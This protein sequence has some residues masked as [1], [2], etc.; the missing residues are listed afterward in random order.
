MKCTKCNA[1]NPN[2]VIFC[3]NCGALVQEAE[4][5]LSRTSSETIVEGEDRA[6]YTQSDE[7]QQPYGQPNGNQPGADANA[8]GNAYS[9]NNAPKKDNDN[10]DNGDGHKADRIAMV[11]FIVI[12]CILLLAAN[13][14]SLVQTAVNGDNIGKMAEKIDIENIENGIVDDLTG[15]EELS[16][17]I[18]KKLPP[19]RREAYNV[20]EDNID[21]ILKDCKIDKFMSDMVEGY[22]TAIAEGRTNYCIKSDDIIDLI[23]DNKKAI[24]KHTGYNFTQ[25]DFDEITA[26]IESGD[27]LDSF[28]VKELEKSMGGLYGVIRITMSK[29]TT[30]VLYVLALAMFIITAVFAGNFKAAFKPCGIMILTIGV[31]HVLILL[32]GML[33]VG[34]IVQVLGDMIGAIILALMLPGIAEIAVGAILTAA[35]IL[36]KINED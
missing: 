28:K 18:Y 21:D 12:G 35:G 27:L 36:L 16:K 6:A 1:E 30:I 11:I 34:G 31:L 29:V 8:Y 22:V 17:W 24:Q 32:I 2:G 15:G 23:K 9:P 4:Q 13:I 5:K 7:V 10:A 14:M 3:M 33:V 19:K 26:E 25:K 20:T